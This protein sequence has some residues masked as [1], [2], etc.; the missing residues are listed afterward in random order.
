MSASVILTTA[1]GAVLAVMGL[2]HFLYTL[3]DTRAPRYFTPSDD[4]VRLAMHHSTLRFAR[5]RTSMWDSW[6]GFNLSHGLGAFVFGA[7]AI[8]V[9]RIA[10]QPHAGL[11]LLALTAISATYLA[12]A[13]RFWFYKPVIGAALATALFLAALVIHIG[14]HR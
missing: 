2:L 9:P 3:L 11:V 14:T 5:G 4:S 10:P 13:V 12:T 6:L 1:A 8:Y 7:A